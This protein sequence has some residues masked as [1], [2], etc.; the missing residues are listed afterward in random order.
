M[1]RSEEE[2]VPVF[3]DG[4]FDIGSSDG[5]WRGKKLVGEEFLHQYVPTGEIKRHT[6]MELIDTIRV[7]GDDELQ[8]S[9]WVEEP[10]LLLTRFEY[11]NVFHT[12]TDFYSAYV[13]SRVTGLPNR[14]HLVFIDGHCETQLQE[15]WQVL[16]S[17]I[18]YA[19]HFSGPVCFHHAILTPLGYETAMF[20]G[21]TEKVDCHGASAHDLW[22]HPDDQRTARLSEFGEMIR[23]AFGFPVDRHRIFKPTSSHNILFVRRED[24]LAHPRHHGRIQTRLH[25]E[26]EVF[27]AVNSWASNQQEYKLNVINGRFA[28]MPMKDQVRAIQDASVIIG[29]HGAAL[30]QIVS[31]EPKTIVLEIVAYKFRRPHFA[32]IAQWKGLKYHPIYLGGSYARPQVVIDELH[33]IVRSLEW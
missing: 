10:T 14:P 28:H 2:E 18:K 31:A 15:T 22:Q 24:Y 13:A 8:C 27:E 30:T 3:E 33:K 29:A 17:S 32:L 26:A 5:S 12:F 25:N 6:M 4:A 11:A 1:G 16:F 20:K 9:E 7:V 19:K 23:A 21:L